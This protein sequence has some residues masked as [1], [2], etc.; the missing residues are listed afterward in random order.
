MP[1]PAMTW[2]VGRNLVKKALEHI[3]QARVLLLAPEMPQRMKNVLF[4]ELALKYKHKD[5][6]KLLLEQAGECLEAN[7]FNKARNLSA[8]AFK[9]GHADSSDINRADQIIQRR[10]DSYN[11][12]SRSGLEDAIETLDKIIKTK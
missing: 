1:V 12:N 10:E 5:E 7:D 3:I 8:Q 2:Y 4:G 9:I 11:D 6:M